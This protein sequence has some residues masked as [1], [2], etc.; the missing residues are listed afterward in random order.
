M[1]C[2]KCQ[3][4]NPAGM[5]FCRQCGDGLQGPGRDIEPRTGKTTSRL[6]PEAERK[7]IT[8]LFSDLSGFTAMTEK[9]APDQVTEITEQIFTGIKQIVTKYDGF[10]E[11]A[12]DDRFL[13]VLGA[14]RSHEHDPVRAIYAAKEIHDLVNS[15]NSEF[16][17]RH[18]VPLAIHTGIETGLVVSADVDPEKG[19]LGMESN[20]INVAS[21]LN[22]LAQPGEILVGHDARGW[23]QDF[24]MFEDLGFR[25]VE[26]MPEAIQIFRVSNAKGLPRKA[27]FYRQVTSEMVGRDKELNNA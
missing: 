7:H 18:G 26:G 4:E 27:R 16:Q 14:H 22:S 6:I 9:L 19:H 17:D 12:T 3:F 10:M 2:R 23:A 20:V 5:R 15:M 21:S 1:K 11:M 24:F 13:V 8:A 25:K